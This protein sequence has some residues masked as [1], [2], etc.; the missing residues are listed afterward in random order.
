MITNNTKTQQNEASR[1]PQNQYKPR[2][3]S[4]TKFE[5]EF[6]DE[7]HQEQEKRKS[8]MPQVD[9]VDV[10]ILDQQSQSS[11]NDDEEDKQMESEDIDNVAHFMT[12]DMEVFRQIDYLWLF[13]NELK[14]SER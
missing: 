3:S 14:F 11:S 13:N 2:K 7:M 6:V 8:V 1:Q 4:I 10:N 9:Q 5:I 12:D